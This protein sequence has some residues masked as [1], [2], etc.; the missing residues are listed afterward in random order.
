M[1]IIRP[2]HLSEIRRHAVE[3]YPEECVG[4]L[5]GDWD[6]A[7]DTRT[8]AETARLANVADDRRSR[9]A[10]DPA[11]MLA[12]MK[13]ER[14]G[15]L[16]LGFYHSHPDVPALPSKTDI[17]LAVPGYCYLIASVDPDGRGD[18]LAWVLRD[19]GDAFRGEKIRVVP[20]P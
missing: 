12:L 5:L 18:E 11:A 19:E 2:E 20:V 4:A 16:V 9:Y 7:A 6:H 1:L 15:R 10:V 13:A 8:V 3:A 14:P 17:A